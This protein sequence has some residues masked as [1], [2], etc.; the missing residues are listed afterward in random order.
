MTKN[1]PD[2]YASG[3]GRPDAFRVNVAAGT[4]SFVKWAGST[5]RAYAADL[6]AVPEDAVTAH[7]V[8]AGQGWL[9]VVNPGPRTRDSLDALLRDAHRRAR[10]RRERRATHQRAPAAKRPGRS[11]L[12]GTSRSRSAPNA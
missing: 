11:T 2:D 9:A 8:Y 3:L 10:A 4:E 12:V 5:P 7:P 6:D 1:Y